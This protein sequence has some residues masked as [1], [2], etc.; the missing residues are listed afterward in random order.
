MPKWQKILSKSWPKELLMTFI[1]ATL[2][3][4]LTFGTAHIVGEKEKKK[5]WST[6][7]YDG[8]TRYG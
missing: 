8:Y 7:C 5:R 3:I 1:G 4:I 2:S 6:G